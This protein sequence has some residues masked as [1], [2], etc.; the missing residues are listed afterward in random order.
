[1]SAL[2][3]FSLSADNNLRAYYNK[4]TKTDRLDAE[5]LAR[6]PALDPEG[7]HRERGLGVA[8]PLRRSVKIR[9]NMVKRR[10]R[11]VQRLDALPKI[12]GPE[13]ALAIGS[14]MC[15]TVLA[16]LARWGDPQQVLRLGR[17]R[18][19][20]WLCPASTPLAAGQL[21]CRRTPAAGGSARGPQ[22]LP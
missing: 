1:V 12:F 22:W 13:W 3:Q 20:R 11:C 18:L 15:S 16:F 6:L 19:T 9:S 14:V 10:T 17:S 8:E 21:H 7:L 4:H 2:V 5:L